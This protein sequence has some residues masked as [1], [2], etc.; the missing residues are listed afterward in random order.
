MEKK[1]SDLI[2]VSAKGSLILILGQMGATFISAIGTIIIARILGAT[3]FGIIA[4]AQI[5]IHLALMSINNGITSAIIHYL[6]ENRYQRKQETIRSIVYTGFLIN[7]TIGLIASL[8]LFLLSGYIANVVFKLNELKPLIQILSFSVLAQSMVNTG[9]SVLI[10]FEK[11]VGRSQISIFY[12]LLKSF[13]GPLLVYFGYGAMGAALG[14]TIPFII[15]GF[16]AM[17]LAYQ[18][19]KNLPV[20][21]TSVRENIFL[22]SRY[23][24]P[25]FLSNFFS[26]G[27]YQIFNFVLP[28]YVS[29]T[30][31][32]NYTAATSFSVLIGFIMTPLNTAIFPLFS[33]IKREDGVLEWIVQN[34]IKYESMLIYPIT[35]GI[36]VFSDH[37]VSILYG[38]TY[39]DTPLFLRIQILNFF[40][41]G[42]GAK[43]TISNL[44][45]SQKKTNINFRATLIYILFGIPMAYFLIPKYGVIGLQITT[46]IAPSMGAFYSLWWLWK[47]FNISVDYNSLGKISL[48]T[49]VSYL[50][51]ALI[52]NFLKYS[53]ILE[54]LIGGIVLVSSYLVAIILTGALNKRNIRDIHQLLRNRA[55]IETIA[56]PVLIF[57]EKYAR[58]E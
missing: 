35:V 40:L 31:I 7:L 37:L 54:I 33:K 24:Y 57:L 1:F 32:G 6:A 45:N 25:L 15:S 3:S 36:L 11:M 13:L 41:I 44:L 21:S 14:Y 26:G 22:L 20:S 29:A 9:S 47:N 10:G 17:F 16:F 30:L 18:S 23:A 8:S 43:G 56:G 58:N 27:L 42:I 2:Q 55:S 46:L 34:L 19:I 28:F 5:P 48:S 51:T 52:V 50:M 49:I 12:S 38:A 39:P 53:P 4:I